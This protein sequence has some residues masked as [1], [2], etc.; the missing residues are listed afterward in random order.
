MKPSQIEV[1]VD[2]SIRKNKNSIGVT[3]NVNEIQHSFHLKNIKFKNSKLNNIDNLEILGILFGSSLS[4]YFQS[5]TIIYNDNIQSVGLI[6]K[7]ISNDFFSVPT[8]FI[9]LSNKN[10]KMCIPDFFSRLG[11]KID[12][13]VLESFHSGYSF[14]DENYLINKINGFTE[15]IFSEHFV[16]DK[17][18]NHVKDNCLTYYDFLDFNLLLKQGLFS[19][20]SC[21]EFFC[22]LKGNLPN[23]SKKNYSSNYENIIKGFMPSFEKKELSFLDFDFN[24]AINNHIE[25]VQKQIEDRDTERSLKKEQNIL[26]TKLDRAYTLVNQINSD[27]I[28]L[29]T[30]LGRTLSSE[31]IDLGFIKNISFVKCRKTKKFKIIKN[32]FLTKDKHEKTN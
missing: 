21:K 16:F 32:K 8:Q 19:D 15:I 27:N 3:F 24:D 13:N 25:S 17:Y 26:L 11:F 6:N 28:K 9:W 14:N 1:Y 4:N 7:L 23:H 10:P 18:I 30:K 2:A 22:Q 31:I 29:N 5:P 20:S 12:S